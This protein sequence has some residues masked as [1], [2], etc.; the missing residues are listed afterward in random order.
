MNNF[1]SDLISILS[2]KEKS[3]C[4]AIG[5]NYL[6]VGCVKGAVY[7]FNPQNLDFLMSL[8]LPHCLGVDIAYVKSIE[9]I[10]SLCN[11]DL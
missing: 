10:D 5:D 8:P 11:L 4:L 9:S 3:N 6:V 1:Q 7:L 2:F